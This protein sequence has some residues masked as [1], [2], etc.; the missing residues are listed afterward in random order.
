MRNKL[1]GLR[2]SQVTAEPERSVTRVS[3]VRLSTTAHDCPWA[4]ALSH[5]MAQRSQHT[6]GHTFQD[7]QEDDRVKEEEREWF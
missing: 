3:I 2:Q 6:S 4:A 5:V 7:R 1:R